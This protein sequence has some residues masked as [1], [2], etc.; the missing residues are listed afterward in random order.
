MFLNQKCA[1]GSDTLLITRKTG[2]RCL[3]ARSLSLSFAEFIEWRVVVVVD[4]FSLLL[5]SFISMGNY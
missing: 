2:D 5:S 4:F 3:L 1:I